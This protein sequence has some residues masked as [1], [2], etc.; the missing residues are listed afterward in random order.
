MTT[1]DR[2]AYCARMGFN[3]CRYQYARLTRR[4]L[5]SGHAWEVVEMRTG[6]RIIQKAKSPAQAFRLWQLWIAKVEDRQFHDALK[7]LTRP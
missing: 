5:A 2:R 1:D 4:G 7:Q 6:A 3:L